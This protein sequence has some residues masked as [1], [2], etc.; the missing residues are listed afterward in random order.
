MTYTVQAGETLFTIAEKFS[1]TLD[2][3]LAANPQIKN[4]DII[5]PGQIINIPSQVSPTPTPTPTPAPPSGGKNEPGIPGEKPLH[6][7]DVTWDGKG[8][9]GLTVIP[10]KPTITVEFDKNVV[11]DAVWENNRKSIT[12]FSSKKNIPIYV[13]RIRDTVDFSMRNKIFI[14]PV[15]PLSPGTVYTLKISPNLKSKAGVT[16]GS[17]TGGYGYSIDLRTES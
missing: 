14:Q 13:T 6:V 4:P 16:L 12:F 7:V 1:I 11:S 8:K 17:S 9:K 15:N 5:L 2:T 3:L 10:I